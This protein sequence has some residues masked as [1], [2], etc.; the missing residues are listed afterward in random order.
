MIESVERDYHDKP[1]CLFVSHLT[2]SCKSNR[3]HYSCYALSGLSIAQRSNIS[4]SAGQ[5]RTVGG[6]GGSRVPPQVSTVL[7]C[8]LLYCTV[9]YCT[10]LYCTVLYCTV[11]Y[12]TLVYCTSHLNVHHRA[13]LYCTLLQ[14]TV[15]HCIEFNR[16]FIDVSYFILLFSLS[17]ASFLVVTKV[18][19]S[20]SCCHCHC[21]SRTVPYRA[22]YAIQSS[23]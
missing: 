17:P 11:L 16:M 18:C 9:L 15:L 7:S 8:S 2:H 1:F 4:T 10:V 22:V 21:L 12:F 20:Q 3:Y 6:S 23:Q 14:C 13:A 5:H 19:V